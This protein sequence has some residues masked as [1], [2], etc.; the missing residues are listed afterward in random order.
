MLES[1]KRDYAWL[2][3]LPWAGHEDS[4]SPRP[5]DMHRMGGI[6]LEQIFILN[7]TSYL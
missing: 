7:L 3:S 6:Y 5:R 1:G 2:G 4:P